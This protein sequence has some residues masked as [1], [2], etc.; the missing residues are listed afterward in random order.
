MHTITT[1][2]HAAAINRPRADAD[3]LDPQA[4]LRLLQ[5]ISPSLPVGG[6]TY[7][8]G[9]EWAVE[10]AWVASVAAFRRWQQRIISDTLS[11]LEWP[12]LNRLY[13]CCEQQDSAG[14][15]DWT[16]FLLA[17]RETRELRQEERQR[18]QALVR[19]LAEWPGLPL[20]EP[21]AAA[22]R[23]SQLAALA[24]L[25]QQWSI[26]LAPLALGYGYSWL[27]SS[28]MAGLKLV[29][30]G[31]QQAQGLLRELAALLPPAYL[32]A[33]TLP[34]DRLGGSFPL[35]AIASACHETQYSRLFR[36]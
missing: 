32:Q 33:S 7:S 13:R 36:S 23:Q 6:F 26:P 5:L 17:S 8:Q 28:V 12:L 20:T 25:G 31:Q 18:G 21:W 16:Q 2:R 22:M 35:Q 9:L 11:T 24:W 19:L 15:A 27:E 14:F 29:P 3:N 30:F 34:D 4:L 10:A 1:D